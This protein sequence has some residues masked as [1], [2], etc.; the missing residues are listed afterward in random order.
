MRVRNPGDSKISVEEREGF[1][2][3]GENKIEYFVS[4]SPMN[5]YYV[6]D[7]IHRSFFIVV[8]SNDTYREC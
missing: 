2:R 5:I 4:P 7:S 1:R 6:I 3:E 8:C